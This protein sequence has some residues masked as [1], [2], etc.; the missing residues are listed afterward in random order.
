[1]LYNL[2]GPLQ[3]IEPLRIAPYKSDDAMD[4]YL[5]TELSVFGENAVRAV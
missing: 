4:E 2:K 3:N 5:G 1:M